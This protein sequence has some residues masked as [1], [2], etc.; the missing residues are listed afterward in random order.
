M[1]DFATTALMEYNGLA[2]MTA[3][4]Q[5]QVHNRFFLRETSKLSDTIDF[6]ASLT[7][8]IAASLKGKPLH[9]IPTPYISRSTYAA[10]QRHLRSRYPEKNFLTSF[11]AY[12]DLNDKTASRALKEQFA[13][14]LMCIKGLSPERAAA[15]LDVFETPR[16]LW[17]AMKVRAAEEAR[18][19]METGLEAPAVKKSKKR[20]ADLF[21]ADRVQGEGRRKIGDALS[22]EVSRQ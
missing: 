21:F 9:V 19:A 22:R 5:I 6:L 11:E 2:I 7:K 17:E 15:I 12:Q 20:G 16:D 13:R 10:L 3:K 18:E 1:E 14:M 4:S 8:T